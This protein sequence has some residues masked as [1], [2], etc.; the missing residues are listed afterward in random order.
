MGLL[1]VC[2]YGTLFTGTFVALHFAEPEV[3]AP[4]RTHPLYEDFVTPVMSEMQA[5]AEPIWSEVLKNPMIASWL[6]LPV[7]GEVADGSTPEKAHKIGPS[8]RDATSSYGKNFSMPSQMGFSLVQLGEKLKKRSVLSTEGN[9]S[10]YFEMPDGSRLWLQH[11]SVVEVGWSDKEGADSEL[12]LRVEKGM[13]HIERPGGATGKVF[14]VTNSGI[15]YSL[16][17]SDGWMAT[18]QM[19]IVDKESFP[20]AESRISGRYLDYVRQATLAEARELSKLLKSDGR[21]E[22]ML[23]QDQL[24]LA[25]ED[26]DKRRQN[27]EKADIMPV[28]VVSIPL[29]IPSRRGGKDLSRELNRMPASVALVKPLK[30]PGR[31]PASASSLD[32]GTRIASEAKILKWTDKGQCSEAKKFFEKLREEHALGEGDAWSLRMKQNFSQ[33]CP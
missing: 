27:L 31:A 17:P 28:E 30:F 15:R 19:G 13:M 26:E 14:L 3:Y 10:T 16:A 7:E 23:Y 11:D 20:D 32:E 25:A 24:R 2:F 12:L 29:E 6:G 21:R 8:D 22:A 18:S 5:L 33:R 9:D 1:R 4:V